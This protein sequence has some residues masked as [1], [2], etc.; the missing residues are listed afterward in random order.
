MALVLNNQKTLKTLLHVNYY[1]GLG[2]L[3]GLFKLAALNGCDGVELRGFNKFEESEEKYLAIIEELKQQYPQ[4]ELTFGYPIDYMK[5]D[6]AARIAEAEEN[7]YKRL[8]WAKEKCGSKL[9][10]FFTGGLYGKNTQYREYYRNGS[11]AAREEHFERAAAGLHR[12]NAELTR[13]DMRI[14]LETHNC[15]L[16]DLPYPCSKLLKMADADR[17]GV[18]Y[19]HGNMFINPNGPQTINEVFDILKGRIFYAHLKN[20][21]R[22]YDYKYAGCLLEQGNINTM[23]VVNLLR[24][25]LPDGIMAIEFPSSG[26]SI[27]AAKRDMEYIRFIQDWLCNNQY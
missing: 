10:N 3:P 22:T 21:I 5:D 13:L 15:Y 2:R 26:D 6:D 4:F 17:V 7:F 16:H 18:N 8:Q 19:D 9:F 11:A 23:R 12:I 14:A 24:N 25:E 1:E 20:M 27:I